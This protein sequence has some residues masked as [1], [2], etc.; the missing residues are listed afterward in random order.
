MNEEK[1][2]EWEKH[3]LAVVTFMPDAMVKYTTFEESER[4]KK[5]QENEKLCANIQQKSR[6]QR[7]HAFLTYRTVYS[8]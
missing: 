2:M 6:A 4:V 5:K 1:K 3:N 7:K 8:F